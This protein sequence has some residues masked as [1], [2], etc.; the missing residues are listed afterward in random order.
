M[1]T[2]LNL[3][4]VT[5]LRT[6]AIAITAGAIGIFVIGQADAGKPIKSIAAD[7]DYWGAFEEILTTCDPNTDGTPPS[8]SADGT[9][10]ACGDGILIYSKT[11]FLSGDA[12][13]LYI[14]LH[15]TGDAHE[16]AALCY[17][18]VLTDPTGTRAFVNAGGQGA[19]RCADGGSTSVPGWITLLK[20]PAGT[21]ATNCDDGG[22]GDGDCHD[23]NINYTWCAAVPQNPDGTPLVGL[24]TVELWM[25]TDTEGLVVFNEQ[26]HFFINE[27][28][29]LATP[30]TCVDPTA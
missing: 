4:A 11:F 23:N 30:N 27:T 8:V 20:V 16:G 15:T 29:I 5:M 13:V 21:G 1:K 26:S 17:T 18:A 19:A 25:A 2:T 6:L 10:I 7:F 24:Y 3:K 14:E 22:G 28:K 9:V 12:N